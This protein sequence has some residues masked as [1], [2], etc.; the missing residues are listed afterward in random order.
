MINTTPRLCAHGW[1][2][3]AHGASPPVRRGETWLA[4]NT[5]NDEPDGPVL[6][7]VGGQRV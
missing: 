2:H 5:G 3:L 1:H 4:P 6:D 7:V